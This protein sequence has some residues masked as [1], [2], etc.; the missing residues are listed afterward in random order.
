MFVGLLLLLVCGLLYNVSATSFQSDG[1]VIYN[2]K[3][4]KRGFCLS[5]WMDET[6]IYEYIREWYDYKVLIS[7]MQLPKKARSRVENC[8]RR[9]KNVSLNIGNPQRGNVIKYTS[10][11]SLKDIVGIMTE[12]IKQ[13]PAKVRVS[14]T[15]KK[16]S[17]KDE[18]LFKY[19]LAKCSKPHKIMKHY[20]KNQFK[21]A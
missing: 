12:W 13:N 10:N 3:R 11:S 17:N 19:G 6:E 20:R 4:I 7:Y 16:S 15:S 5:V 8:E 21:V 2:P 9:K 14:C 1:R 18:K